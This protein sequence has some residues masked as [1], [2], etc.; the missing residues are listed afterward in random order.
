MFSVC[1]ASFIFIM[2]SSFSGMPISGTHTVVGALLGAGIVAT[3]FSNLNWT[4]LGYIVLS[5]FVSP[6]LAA[7]IT[8]IL[9]LLVSRF[10]M[11][12][13]KVGFRVRILSLQLISAACFVTIAALLSSLIGYKYQLGGSTTKTSVPWRVAFYV[14][15]FLA[16]LAAVRLVILATLVLN[17]RAA[18]SGMELAR[19]VFLAV[20]LPWST[21]F[22]EKLTLDIELDE[23]AAKGSGTFN[24]DQEFATVKAELQ[25]LESHPQVPFS[26]IGAH[27]AFLATELS[28]KGAPGPNEALE[29]LLDNQDRHD[30]QSIKLYFLKQAKLTSEVYRFLMVMS[31]ALVCLSHGSN[32]VGNAISPLLIL[33]NIEGQPV[34]FSFLLGS[35][36]IA[37]GL[38]VMG[39]KVMETVGKD[40]VVLDFMKGFSSQ[41]STATCVCLG[42]SLG[43]PLSTT[44]CMIGALA[45]VYLAGKSHT[46]KQV[47]STI[48][49]PA[50]KKDET[51]PDPSKDVYQKQKPVSGEASKMNFGTVK[52]ILFWWAITIPC[53]M[54]A[55]M[56]LCWVLVKV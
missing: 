11:N 21:E 45:G 25:K 41:F 40:I 12:T 56:A 23:D 15:P 49:S 53:S 16:G 14:L 35:A 33:M 46:M 36:G 17:A 55:T 28:A 7:L 1:L 50:E 39:V 47:Y 13:S 22:I 20:V 54:G 4:K 2:T 44:H 19:L 26:D 5:W 10:T 8:C 9:M 37:L 31:A 24:L 42:S 18:I 34:Y 52:K 30:N 48:S 3:G 29:G 38:L 32:D 51:T 27:S 43:M 6:A